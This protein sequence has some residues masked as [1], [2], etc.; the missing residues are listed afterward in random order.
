MSSLFAL[1]PVDPETS[2]GVCPDIAATARR[3][4]GRCFAGGEQILLV[5]VA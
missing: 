2:V 1:C 4:G 3:S 5:T